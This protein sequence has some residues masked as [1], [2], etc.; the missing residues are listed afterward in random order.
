MELSDIENLILTVM[1]IKS[2]RAVVYRELRGEFSELSQNTT[3]AQDALICRRGVLSLLEKG[4]LQVPEETLPAILMDTE[5]AL[6]DKGWHA[7]DTLP[8]RG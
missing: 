6:T 3:Y 7:I 8:V 4:L 1:V 2:K 5:I